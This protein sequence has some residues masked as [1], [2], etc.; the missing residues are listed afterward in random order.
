M[1]VFAALLFASQHRHCQT[2]LS[3][4]TCFRYRSDRSTPWVFTGSHSVT[5]RY[6]NAYCYMLLSLLLSP[7]SLLRCTCTSLH[8]PPDYVVTHLPFQYPFY[9]PLPQS[10]PSLFQIFCRLIQHHSFASFAL[11]FQRH[12]QNVL[13]LSFSNSP[14]ACL[15]PSYMS[16]L[17]LYV[18]Y[19]LIRPLLFI[20]PFP[21]D[22]SIPIRCVHSL[23]IRA[24]I[25]R[26]FNRC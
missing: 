20:R 11:L 16:I 10:S 24:V 23:S 26:R 25:H 3:Y 18:H 15:F 6:K 12:F 22:A 7:C 13:F 19:I 8:T 17:I 2:K 14:S 9:T 1:P 4:R 5:Q 21:Y